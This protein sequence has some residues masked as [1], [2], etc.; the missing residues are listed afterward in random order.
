MLS[1]LLYEK[2]DNIHLFY[3]N[4]LVPKNQDIL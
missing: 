4:L 3:M 1:V 2:F